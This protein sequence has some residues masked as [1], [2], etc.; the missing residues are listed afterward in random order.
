MVSTTCKYFSPSFLLC[1][2]SVNGCFWLPPFLCLTCLFF[3]V[4]RVTCYLFSIE[5]LKTQSYANQKV[6]YNT[7]S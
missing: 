1:A 2:S 6:I 3:D 4:M 5:L 7:F